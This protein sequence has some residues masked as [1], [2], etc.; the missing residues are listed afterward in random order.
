MNLCECGKLIEVIKYK[1]NGKPLCDEC[2]GKIK[3]KAVINDGVTFNTTKD[4]LYHFT[5]Q[6]SPAEKPIEI[7]GKDHWEKEIKKRGLIDDFTQDHKK[8]LKEMEKRKN[9]DPRIS[10]EFIVDQISRELKSKGLYNKLVKR[11]R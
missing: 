5:H 10:H 8:Y 9:P 2:W 6:F 4:K 3:I 7:R 1:H 11:R